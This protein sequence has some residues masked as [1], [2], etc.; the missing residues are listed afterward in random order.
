MKLARYR[1]DG[2]TELGVVVDQA[3]VGLAAVGLDYPDMAAL[4][5]DPA[6]LETIRARTAGAAPQHRLEDVRL[7]APL[8]PG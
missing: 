7:L 1:I 3:I 4:I 2:R 8:R 6:A 5:A